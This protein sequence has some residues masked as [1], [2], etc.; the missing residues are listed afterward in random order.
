M[1]G[2]YF[3]AFCGLTIGGLLAFVLCECMRIRN[4][5][6]MHGIVFWKKAG[7]NMLFLTVLSFLCAVGFTAWCNY[8]VWNPQSR[9]AVYNR[10]VKQNSIVRRAAKNEIYAQ[11]MEKGYGFFENGVFQWKEGDSDVEVA[12]KSHQ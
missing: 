4:R 7:N 9:L 5:T 11:A 8:T 12:G 1:E 3:F 10:Q 2:F 6:T